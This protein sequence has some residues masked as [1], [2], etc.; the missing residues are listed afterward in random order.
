VQN[1]EAIALQKVTGVSSRF[2]TNFSSGVL[3]TLNQK[4]AIKQNKNARQRTVLALHKK[5]PTRAAAK[6]NFIICA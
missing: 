1:A 3:K 4:A 5:P 2:S 6:L